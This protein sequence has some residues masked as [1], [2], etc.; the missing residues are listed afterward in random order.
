MCSYMAW[1]ERR[2]AGGRVAFSRTI[3]RT[4]AV[5]GPSL[6]Y[7]RLLGPYGCGCG[8][9]S[10]LRTVLG[11]MPVSRATCRCD[12]PSTKIQRLTFAHCATSRYMRGHLPSEGRRMCAGGGG[13]RATRSATG[14]YA[15]AAPY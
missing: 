13:V 9:A 10:I 12:T 5:C 8:W 7:R 2:P 11:L 14:P 3:R 15:Q 1:T 6:G 4:E